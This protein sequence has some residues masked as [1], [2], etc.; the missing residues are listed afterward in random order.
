MVNV[1]LGYRR[2][3]TYTVVRLKSP[4]RSV[5]QE[6]VQY[7]GIHRFDFRRELIILS[8]VFIVLC[9]W[10]AKNRF[11]YYIYSL[12]LYH[13]S[14]YCHLQGGRPPYFYV[15]NHHPAHS[16]LPA[17]ISVA[18][19]TEIAFVLGAPFKSISE[20]YVNIITTKYSEIEKGL[21]L[22]VMK[23]WSDFAK[24]G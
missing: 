19:G 6:V 4:C 7:V 22:Y 5:F 23:L 15:F 12:T 18:H 10:A 21:S 3:T 1:K 16:P 8:F 20:P 24:F 14:Y 17:W 13:L 9:S 11:A 2:Q